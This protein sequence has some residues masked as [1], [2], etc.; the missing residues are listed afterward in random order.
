MRTI[1]NIENSKI[2]RQEYKESTTKNDLAVDAV[3][4]QFMRELGATCIATRDKNNK[5]IA[6]GALDDLPSVA[7][8]EPRK[9]YWK[10]DRAIV[11]C[12]NCGRG[13]KDAFGRTSAITYNFCPNCGVDMRGEE[14]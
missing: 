6:L 14:E 8:Q 12:S 11:R 3:S 13:Y 5:L 10:Y 4:R 1:A 9:G 7:P 2:N